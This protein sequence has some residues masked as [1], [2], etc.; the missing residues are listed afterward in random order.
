MSNRQNHATPLR[1][2]L[3]EDVED[4]AQLLV[5]HL[6][7]E[8]LALDW[9]RIDTERDVIAGLQESWDIV[10]SDFSMPNLSGTRALEIV[11]QHDPD[12][13]FIFVSATI[14]E[15]IAVKA[16]KSGAQDYIMKDNLARLLPA[17]ERELRD[18]HVRR[19]RRHAEQILR[20]LSLAV[21]QTTDSVFITD[22]SGCIE[23]VNPAFEE[24]TGYTA[25]EIKGRTSAVFSS[26]RHDAVFFQQLWRTITRGD[27]FKGTLINRRKNGELFFEEKVI[28]PLKDADGR[29]THFVS[30]GR[31]VTAR[32]RA[33]EA[34]TRLVS[35]LEATPDLVAI[36]GQEGLLRYLNQ[37]GRRLLGINAGEEVSARYMHDLVVEGSARQRMSQALSAV[38][39][40]G[41]WHGETVLRI[42][43]EKEL[44]VSQVV[45][46]HRNT[47]GA[48]EYLSTIMRDISERKHYEAQ[49]QYQSTHDRLTDLPNRFYLMDRLTSALEY[50][51]RHGEY[52]AV[53]FL[54]LNNFKRINDNLGHSAGDSLLRQVAQ[55]L[56]SC[57]RSNDTVA[58]HGGDEFTVVASAIKNSEDVLVLL[59]KLHA[60]FERPVVINAQNIYITLSIGIAL[61][62]HDGDQIEELLHH[63]DIA[64]Y[65]AKSSGPNQYR[66]YASDM[67]A[68]SHELLALES[69]LRL[70]L[71]HEQFL[72]YYQPQLDLRSDRIIGIEGLIRW[73][74][75]VRGLISPADFVPLLENSG[76]II[77]VGEWVLRQACSAHRTLREAGFDNFRVSINVSAA[78]FND[79]YLFE[80]VNRILQDEQM[81]QQMLE[82]EITENIL[83]KDPVSAAEVLRA[84]NALGVRVAIDDFGTG[85]SSLA[86][87]KRFPLDVLKIDQTFVSDLANDPSDAAIVEASISL[88]HKLD[89]EVIAEGVETAK[90][91][92]FMR[93][94]NCDMAQG[95]YFSQPLPWPELVNLYK[96]N[97]MDRN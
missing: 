71:E 7:S 21:R 14:G 28:T 40:H 89:L 74:H 68:R 67:N 16:M 51:K 3:I 57:F 64:M 66:F 80:R 27:L 39:E 56:K 34:N 43:E 29:I 90:Q 83:M 70:A 25:D 63:A 31:D 33:E 97:N 26:G 32:V 59:Q 84:I 6:E 4:D 75:P 93:T 55:R 69:D 79:D 72:L 77:P 95:Y 88:A 87:L 50:A 10:V 82:L 91:L 5:D 47:D 37:A 92:R 58:R 36:F 13:P 73:Q 15:E 61:Y 12:I 17:I 9:R 46:A 1:V 11:R 94:H 42:A 49:L 48:I 18:A 44:P 2:L 52:V 41:V 53:L 38:R 86:Y 54:D 30:T 20:K 19:E 23:Y 85:Y 60:V 81:P 62:P 76:M 8:G 78:Q 22:A 96:E 35:I 24:L 65:R 45:L